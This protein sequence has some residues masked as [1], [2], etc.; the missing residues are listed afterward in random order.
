MSL[1][2]THMADFETDAKI[3]VRLGDRIDK[4]S[5]NWLQRWLWKNQK[6]VQLCEEICYVYWDASASAGSKK[7]FERALKR[8]VRKG[9]DRV[10]VSC[11]DEI[12]LDFAKLAAKNFVQ[13]HDLQIWLCVPSDITISGTAISRLEDMFSEKQS[14]AQIESKTSP[15]VS[16]P[17]HRENYLL[18]KQRA[19]R[20]EAQ[21]QASAPVISR[22]TE[23]ILEAVLSM[24]EDADG[25]TSYLAE[26]TVRFCETLGASRFGRSHLW[27]AEHRIRALQ[28]LS[29]FSDQQLREI[30]YLMQE[31]YEI[32]TVP[33]PEEYAICEAD[34]DEAPLLEVAEDFC[35][36][37]IRIE[38]QP[39]AA[40]LHFP[41]PQASRP[42]AKKPGLESSFS[43]IQEFL[44]KNDAGFRD[45]LLKYID[46]TGKKDSVIYKK[47]NIDRRLYSKILNVQ[48]YNPSKPTAIAFAIAL[49][50]NLEETKDLI[51]RAGYALSAASTFD[52]IVE[53]FIL[54]GNYD[55]YEINEA[56]F[57]FD[58]SLLGC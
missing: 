48:G 10:A 36:P 32:I 40:M 7:A 25:N 35:E 53:F 30:E 1:L 22:L 58:Q 17:S 28:E 9:C 27:E 54:E 34:F 20:K 37:K 42:Q 24:P 55:I 21:K 12:S 44:K 46:R 26:S 13:K 52:R 14:A 8:A 2:I 29:V 45:T 38:D 49:E 11:E 33:E 39:K 56:L 50:L 31:L 23:I 6:N 47:A 16:A 43:E 51:G 15:S 3:I 41:A 19:R 57:H 4:Q 5:P 18:E